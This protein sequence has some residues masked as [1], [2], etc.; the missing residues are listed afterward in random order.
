MS[1]AILP[2]VFQCICSI[3]PCPSSTDLEEMTR[4]YNVTKWQQLNYFNNW[5]FKS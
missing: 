2:K 3:I 4:F 1:N 5:H